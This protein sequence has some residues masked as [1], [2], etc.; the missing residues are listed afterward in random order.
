LA[1]H[2]ALITTRYVTSLTAPAITQTMNNELTS[3]PTW[4]IDRLLESLL[5]ADIRV[6]AKAFVPSGWNGQLPT[7]FRLVRDLYLPDNSQPVGLP[8]F[9][10]GR[11]QRFE[12]QISVVFVGLESPAAP[13]R[14]TEGTV[15][16]RGTTAVILHGPAVVELTFPFLVEKVPPDSDNYWRDLRFPGTQF[17]L[18]FSTRAGK[19]DMHTAGQPPSRSDG[20]EPKP[21]RAAE[22]DGS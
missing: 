21:A 9:F 8:V 17:E 5:G 2:T 14:A 18:P 6:S 20:N 3:R 13:K 10:E 16:F 1:G 4:A 22:G 19:G 12:R 11:L 15:Y 7:R